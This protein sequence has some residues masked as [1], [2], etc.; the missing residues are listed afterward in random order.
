MMWALPTTENATN[1]Q[2]LSM[3]KNRLGPTEEQFQW[4]TPALLDFS[5]LYASSFTE[6]SHFFQI[7][8]YAT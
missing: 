5:S 1:E 6:I 8:S 7:A 3:F 4:K 2:T